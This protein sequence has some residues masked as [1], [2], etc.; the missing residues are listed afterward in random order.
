MHH[1]ERKCKVSSPVL[2]EKLKSNFESICRY[3]LITDLFDHLDIL[4]YSFMLKSFT[5]K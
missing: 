5:L 1:V 4:R 2:K 3:V